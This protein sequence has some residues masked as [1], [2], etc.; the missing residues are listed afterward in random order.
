MTV[1]SCVFDVSLFLF[2]KNL[3]FSVT[4]INAQVESL[5]V[6]KI[7]LLQCPWS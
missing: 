6:I 3:K 4:D 5:A 2:I 1:V 7:K